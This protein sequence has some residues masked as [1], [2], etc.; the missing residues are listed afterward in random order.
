MIIKTRP[1]V[2]ARC[3]SGSRKVRCLLFAITFLTITCRL[4]NDQCYPKEGGGGVRADDKCRKV[5]PESG[6]DVA[7]CYYIVPY[8][9]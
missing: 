7:S 6:Y 3:N 2:I 5:K 8:F 9:F 4:K 1:R